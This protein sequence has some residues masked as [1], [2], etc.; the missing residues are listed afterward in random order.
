MKLPRHPAGREI[1]AQL[2]YFRILMMEFKSRLILIA[3]IPL[4]GSLL[5]LVIGQLH[6]LNESPEIATTEAR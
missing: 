1:R 3:A 6:R 2:A 4:M 5:F